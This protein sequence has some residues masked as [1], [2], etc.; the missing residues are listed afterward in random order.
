M[1]YITFLSVGCADG[2]HIRYYGDDNKW[3]NIFIDGGRKVTYCSSVKPI[4]EQIIKNNESIDMWIITHIDDDHIGALLYALE[5]DIATIHKCISDNTKVLYNYNCDDD[6]V[7]NCNN[8]ELKSVSQG[9]RLI[10]L[11]FE[12]KISVINNITST[13]DRINLY[14]A[15]IVFLSPS[16]EYYTNFINEWRSKTIQRAIKS[17]I[18]YKS[19]QKSDYNIPY[20]ALVNTVYEEDKSV[21]NRS[22][23]AFLFQFSEQR[24]I[25]TAD[26][27]ATTLVDSLKQLGYSSENKINLD[28]LQL[29]HHGSRYNISDELLQVVECD[30]YIISANA[31]NKYNLP[32]KEAI[33][34]VIHA[35]RDKQ[36]NV[37]VTCNNQQLR[38]MF[39]LD[40]DTE[41]LNVKF[42]YSNTN[43]EISLQD[44]EFIYSPN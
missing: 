18:E 17:D 9:I 38:D 33:S 26:S 31:I 23:I 30:N 13:S 11:L 2:I 6:Y 43:I 32:N 7:V 25:F 21:W 12:N 1:L 27:S 34:R 10:D 14:G 29:P 28:C 42:K 8:G 16:L 36:I 15:D 5:Y 22:S 35:K 20:K 24:F 39:L 37:F 41:V 3:H 4:I 44:G 19:G 40:K